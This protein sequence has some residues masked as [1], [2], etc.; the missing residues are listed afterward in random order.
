MGG[1]ITHDYDLIEGIAVSI[2]GGNITGLARLENVAKIYKDNKVKALLHDSAPLISADKVWNQGID[3]KGVRVCV[4]DSGLDYTHPAI[5]SGCKNQ[6]IEGNNETLIRESPHPYRE[7]Y[8][9]TWTITKPN[10]TSIAVHFVNISTEPGY[11]KVYIKDAVGNIID[12]YS[13]KVKDRWSKAVSGDTIKINLVSDFSIN[14]YGFYIDQVLNGSVNYGWTNCIKIIG[15]YDF[16]NNDEDPFDDLGHGTHVTGIIS[17]SDSYARGI[18]NGAEL[19]IAK[20][21]DSRGYGNESDV[22]EAVD[23]CVNN[24]AQ[25]ISMSLGSEEF[26]RTC[27][28]VPL[29]QAVINATDKGAIVIVAAGN[30]GFKG[31][32]EPACSSKAIAVGA[33]DK[34]SNVAGFSSKGSE[35]DILA[36]GYQINSTFPEGWATKSGTSMATP[37]VTGVIALML[38]KNPHL[39]FQDIMKILNETS[40]PVKKCYECTRDASGYCLNY[41]YE[42]NCT[43]NV[44]GAGIVNASRAVEYV[45]NGCEVIKVNYNDFYPRYGAEVRKI[46]PEP[47]EYL[48]TS[49]ESGFV[50]SCSV[51]NEGSY[52]IDAWYNGSQFGANT[53]L[54]VDENGEGNAVIQDDSS[55]PNET[56]TCGNGECSGYRYC[57]GDYIQCSSWNTKCSIKKCC[58]CNGG[59]A[60]DPQENYDET[61]NS[62]CTNFDLPEIATCDWSPDDYH[63]TWDFKNSFNSYCTGLDQCKELDSNVTHT[64]DVNNC[65]AECDSNDDCEAL[66][67][68]ESTCLGNCTCFRDTILPNITILSPKNS[69]YYSSLINLT[70][71]VDE[72]TS[73]I[74]YSLDGKTNIT[75]G[76]NKP[77]GLYNTTLTIPSTVSHDVMV[78]ANDTF[79]NIGYSRVYFTVLIPTTIPTKTCQALG[80][81]CMSGSNGCINYCSRKRLSGYAELPVSTLGYYP[82]C[83]M[84]NVC[85]ICG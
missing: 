54:N 24:S 50:T 64:C 79:G 74:G 78:Y 26:N 48:G 30:S 67:G 12:S 81:V 41:N 46:W 4:V 16:V 35:L 82:G 57:I 53:S 1:K 66:Y 5:E 27:D 73:W 7:N 9:Y 63:L 44:T 8:D 10:Y 55:Y 69:I 40:D 68:I 80:G 56:E 13:G 60:Y 51:L 15:G 70:F 49:N 45:D 85:C 52:L 20:V 61:Q 6:I 84:G 25:L 3:G 21:L 59:T 34:N 83:S 19:L 62:D 42:I 71:N 65:N 39:S 29:S 22:I 11:D 47:I 18:A 32:T 72:K 14:D 31:I 75:F 23:W 2:D 38:E 77:Y 58:K 36:P 76:Y 28:D 43:R 33:I 37:H 17:S